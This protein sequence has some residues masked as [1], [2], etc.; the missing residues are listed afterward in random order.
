[1]A[2]SSGYRSEPD[3]PIQGPSAITFD[4]VN[5]F[6]KT[7]RIS[8]ALAVRPRQVEDEAGDDSGHQ[9]L[10][11]GVSLACPIRP[12]LQPQYPLATTV[13]TTYYLVV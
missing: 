7:R 6:S 1:M 13:G 11:A 10:T 2:Y 5:R 3:K 12:G 9:G 8:R 4:V